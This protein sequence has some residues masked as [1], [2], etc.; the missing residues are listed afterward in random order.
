VWR[1]SQSTSKF[2]ACFANRS[3]LF[4]GRC[5]AMQLMPAL[6]AEQII[7]LSQASQK[8]FLSFSFL[9]AVAWWQ[10]VAARYRRLRS[11]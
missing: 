4:R 9:H 1:I 7:Q 10:T 6:A 2:F 3:N 11:T 5:A 8:R